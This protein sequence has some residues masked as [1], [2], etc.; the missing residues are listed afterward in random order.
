MQEMFSSVGMSSPHVQDMFSP[1]WDVLHPVQ[2]L[3]PPM[4]YVLPPVG[5]VLFYPVLHLQAV[6]KQLH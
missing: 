2:N 3:L 4:Q 5:D 1:V 6:W